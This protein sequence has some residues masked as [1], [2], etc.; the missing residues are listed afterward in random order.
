[1]RLHEREECERG[2]CELE[3]TQRWTLSYTGEGLHDRG[4]LGLPYTAILDLGIEPLHMGCAR[5]SQLEP[6]IKAESLT[7]VGILI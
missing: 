7:K 4:P 2:H 5:Q 3:K 1:M 6:H